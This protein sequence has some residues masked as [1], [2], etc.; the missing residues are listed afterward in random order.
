MIDDV[1]IQILL[2]GREHGCREES[3]NP[4][5]IKRENLKP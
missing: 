3:F 2:D 4:A 1:D 5:T